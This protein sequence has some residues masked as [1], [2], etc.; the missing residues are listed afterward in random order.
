MARSYVKPSCIECTQMKDIPSED[1][2]W[3]T[4]RHLD[5][6]V[7]CRRCSPEISLEE[8]NW[9]QERRLGLGLIC[10]DCNDRFLISPD[11]VV[12][13]L[14]HDLKL[15]KRCPICRQENKANRELEEEEM[16]PEEVVI[17]LDDAVIVLNEAAPDGE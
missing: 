17:I 11:E 2:A 14:E 5:L 16:K 13:L 9:L 3:L 1:I 15:F 12:W 7:A 10:K 6:A 8:A 4:E